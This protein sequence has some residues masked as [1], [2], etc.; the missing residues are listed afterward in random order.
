MSEIKQGLAKD[1]TLHV[2]SAIE[3]TGGLA[4]DHIEKAKKLLQELDYIL[5]HDYHVSG[6]V[7]IAE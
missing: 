4:L 6:T 3:A 1:I 5:W 2:Q 7:R